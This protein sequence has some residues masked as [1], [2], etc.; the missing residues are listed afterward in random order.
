MELMENEE[1]RQKNIIQL[2]NGAITGIELLEAIIREARQ[3]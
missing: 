1:Q 3:Q 2:R